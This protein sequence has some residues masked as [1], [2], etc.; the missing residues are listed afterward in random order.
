MRLTY[1]RRSGRAIETNGVAAGTKQILNASGVL[2]AG[3]QTW[4]N[5]RAWL[6]R[7]GWAET[8]QHVHHWFFAQNSAIGKLIPDVIKNMKWNLLPIRDGIKGMTSAEAHIAIHG[9]G[10]NAMGLVER[11]LYGTPQWAK[12]AA[13]S[14]AGRV[15]NR[16]FKY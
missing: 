8:G 6:G 11:L 2:K 9:M 4:K 1:C 15:T 5:T 16:S 13:G 7:Q 3:S 14:V 12:A 10:P